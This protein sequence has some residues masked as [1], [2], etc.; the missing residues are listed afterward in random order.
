MY[1]MP[2]RNFGDALNP[3]LYQKITGRKAQ[4]V[5]AKYG[6]KHYMAIGSVLNN[7]NNNTIAWGTGLAWNK[8]EVHPKAD[9]R[10]VRGP[11]TRDIAI[12]NGCNCPEI[13]GDPALLLPRFYNPDIEK[14]YKMGIIP[15]IIDKELLSK[16]KW[17]DNCTLIDLG[18]PIE[19][20]INS[21]LKCETVISSSLHGLI[22]ADAYGI[23]SK[24]VEF[25]DRVLGDNTKFFDHFDAVQ[26]PRYQPIN[27]RKPQQLGLITIPSYDTVI[28]LDKLMDACPFKR[29]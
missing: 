2:G 27:L 16:Y 25:S 6:Q 17:D 26:I 24:W 4:R 7:S 23:P 28:D 3:W 9:I 20:V 8:N 18:G 14:T 11:L 1:W 22:L 19:T 12:R 5:N 15:H 29:K 10:A 13:Y 21:V